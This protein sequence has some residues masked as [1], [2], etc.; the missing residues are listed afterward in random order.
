MNINLHNYEAF[1]LDYAEGNLS[2]EVVTELILFMEEHPL[3]KVELDHFSILEISSVSDISFNKETLYSELQKNTSNTSYNGKLE[4]ATNNYE[5]LK[6][7]NDKQ[8]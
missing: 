5:Q 2:A 3:L 8:L 6:N 7:K 4:K 1:Y